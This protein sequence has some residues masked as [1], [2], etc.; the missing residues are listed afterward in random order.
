VA[1]K[2]EWHDSG[3]FTALMYNS[4]SGRVKEEIGAK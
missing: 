3:V 1:N 2:T 4:G